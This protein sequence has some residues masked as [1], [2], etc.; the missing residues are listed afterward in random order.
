MLPPSTVPALDLSIKLGQEN[1]RLDT[2]GKAVTVF[3]CSLNLLQGHFCP[4]TFSVFHAK[5][6][7]GQKTETALAATNMCRIIFITFVC[8][9]FFKVLIAE[10]A[11]LLF[12]NTSELLALIR[13]VCCSFEQ[14]QHGI[15]PTLSM[16]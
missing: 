15:S 9:E 6:Q 14:A 12:I 1:F 16:S 11:F 3:C 7:M 13:G 4:R 5:N 8:K 2:V 10:E